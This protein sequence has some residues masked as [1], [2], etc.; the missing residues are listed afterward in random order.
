M[1]R[2]LMLAGLLLA[3]TLPAP[4]GWATKLVTYNYRG[5]ARLGAIKGSNVIDL[6]RAYRMMLEERGRPRAEAL[7]AALVPANMLEFL[8]G[9]EES[10]R[11]AQAALQ[12]TRQMAGSA[13]G[14]ERL[15]REGVWLVQSEVTFQ[16]AL[17]NPPHVLAIGQNYRKHIEEM[18]HVLGDA[19]QYP[20][21]FSKHGSIIGPGETIRV[22]KI[23]ENTDYE[24]ELVAVIGKPARNVTK[25]TALD[26]VAGYIVGNDVT[27]RDFQNRTSQW[28]VGKGPDTFTALGGYLVLKDEIPN[29]QSLKIGTRVGSEV[30]Q[31]SNTELMIFT[32]ADMIAYISQV[33]TLEPGVIIFTGTPDG[34]G[35]GRT[36]PRWLKPGETV[37]VEIE[38][39]GTLSNPIA[40]E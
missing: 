39:V 14:L 24:A 20:N 5:Q 9:Q 34:V 18:G 33:M 32:V 25:E 4:S 13:Q 11:E 30:L 3:V 27:S 1:K 36:P 29:P 22:P 31:D 37:T 6:N 2:L 28:I 12:F 17:P 21:V 19:A 38:K 7:A 16:A 40:R 10:L 15:K 23:V 8:Q 35:A 26:Y